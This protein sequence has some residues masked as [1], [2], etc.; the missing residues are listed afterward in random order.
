MV[1]ISEE[2]KIEIDDKI[3]DYDLS[4]FI[5]MSFYKSILS[6]DD[7]EKFKFSVSISDIMIN[8]LSKSIDE[9]YFFEMLQEIEKF[10]E[11]FGKKGEEIFYLIK[12]SRI[13]NRLRDMIETGV[14]L[15]LTKKDNEID[16]DSDE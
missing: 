13:A 15:D 8:S 12:F 5:K 16:S 6:Q 2:D 10:N 7:F 3:K 11:K 1:K 14:M 4:D 9:N